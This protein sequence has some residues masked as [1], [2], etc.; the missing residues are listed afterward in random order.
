VGGSEQELHG[1]AWFSLSKRKKGIGRRVKSG[2]A[3]RTKPESGNVS[4]L[5]SMLLG[6]MLTRFAFL[7]RSRVPLTGMHFRG[8]RY[9]R[10]YSCEAAR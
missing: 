7:G 3:R 5:P 2:H 1:L 4:W 8:F 6:V 10:A 9:S